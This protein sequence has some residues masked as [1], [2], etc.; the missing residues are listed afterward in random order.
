MLGGCPGHGAS[1]KG[2][3]DAGIAIPR[4]TA[5][6][7]TPVPLPKLKVGEPELAAATR[8]GG[9]LLVCRAKAADLVATYNDVRIRFGGSQ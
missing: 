9:E 6:Q 3:I 2:R 7:E 5:A 8:L 4:L 1:T